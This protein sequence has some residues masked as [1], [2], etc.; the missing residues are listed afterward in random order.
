MRLTADAR[1]GPYIIDGPIG[2]GGM[3]EVYR[4]RHTTLDRHV[5]IKVLPASLAI[6]ADA[7]ARFEREDAGSRDWRCMPTS[8]RSEP[9][10]TTSPRGASS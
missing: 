3:G 8:R 9:P 4:A 7:R 2:A 1:L 5:A 10:S 6:A